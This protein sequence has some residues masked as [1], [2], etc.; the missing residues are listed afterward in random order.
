MAK[1][2][3]PIPEGFHTVT[4]QL[5]DVP[6]PETGAMEKARLIGVI[7][8]D[9]I[10]RDPVGLIS[11]IGHGS[12]ATWGMATNVAGVLNTGARYDIF[13]DAWSALAVSP[14]PGRL[15]PTAVWSGNEMI[16]YGGTDEATYFDTAAEH[17]P[18]RTLYLYT[19]P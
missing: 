18:P 2:K 7:V 8:R 9:S 5:T 4:P 12:R 3:S 15:G 6:N 11:A 13:D 19:R 1:A 17:I 14:L 10:V 16:I